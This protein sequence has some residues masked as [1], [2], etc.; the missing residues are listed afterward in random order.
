M[1]IENTKPASVKP[2][3]VVGMV[4]RQSE[5]RRFETAYVVENSDSYSETVAAAVAKA[6]ELKNM[7]GDDVMIVVGETETHSHRYNE[8]LGQ[9]EWVENTPENLMLNQ[10]IWINGSYSLE[11]RRAE[12]GI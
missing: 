9:F 7:N 6:E 5:K 11:W 2:V 12:A 10:S 1:A 8:N 4:F 3:I